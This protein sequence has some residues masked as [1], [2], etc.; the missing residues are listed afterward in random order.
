MGTEDKASHSYGGRKTKRTEIMYKEGGH[1]Y[2]FLIYG[3]YECFNVTVASEG[4]SSGSS[5]KRN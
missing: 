3:M 4:K 2:V 5:Y 1:S